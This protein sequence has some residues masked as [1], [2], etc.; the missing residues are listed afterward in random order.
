MGDDAIIIHHLLNYKLKHNVVVF[1]KDA[2]T[3]VVD[4]LKMYSI[5]F[6]IGG[7]AKYTFLNNNYLTFKSKAYQAL[8][9]EVRINRIVKKI[10]GLDSKKLDKLIQLIEGFLNES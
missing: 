1:S 7:E 5:N 2:L 10:E 6:E 9:K 8:D 4:T 3:K